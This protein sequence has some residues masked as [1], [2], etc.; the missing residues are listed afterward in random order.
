MGCTP[1]APTPEE[2]ASPEACRV[3]REDEKS[4]EL[5]RALTDSRDSTELVADYVVLGAGSMGLGFVDAL[6]ASNSTISVIIVDNRAHPG[7]H[8]NDAYYCTPDKGSNRSS[9][10]F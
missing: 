5:M 4:K 3:R 6:L 1:G 2:D 8:W 7:G 9:P 10:A